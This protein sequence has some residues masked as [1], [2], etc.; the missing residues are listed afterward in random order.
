MPLAEF[1]KGFKLIT[2]GNRAT[3]KVLLL[4]FA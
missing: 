2:T 3:G 4:P 1:D